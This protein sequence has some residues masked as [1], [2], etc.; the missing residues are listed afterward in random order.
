MLR[1]N[2]AFIAPFWAH[3]PAHMRQ[4]T[5]HVTFEGNHSWPETRICANAFNKYGPRGLAIEFTHSPDNPTE[6]IGRWTTKDT[7]Q[8]AIDLIHSHI[9]TNTIFFDAAFFG[10]KLNLF[11]QATRIRRVLRN[12]NS[13]A[14]PEY[15]ITGKSKTALKT[16]GQDD[17]ILSFL[18]AILSAAI[19]LA[20]TASLERQKTWAPLLAQRAKLRSAAATKRI[21]A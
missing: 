4:L 11:E 6:K 5:W 16:D 14:G 3:L 8:N 2:Q 20:P 12:L 15:Y 9:N 13:A 7:K 17:Q 10:D 18:V 21:C 19:V 1:V